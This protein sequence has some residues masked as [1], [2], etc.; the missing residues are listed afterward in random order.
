[1]AS[2]KLTTKIT[3]T[4]IITAAMAT[5][6]IAESVGCFLYDTDKTE[7]SYCKFVWTSGT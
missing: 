7:C 6:D 2:N 1:L 4:A 3:T 5:G